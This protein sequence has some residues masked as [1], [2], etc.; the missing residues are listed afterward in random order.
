MALLSCGS[1]LDRLQLRVGWESSEAVVA[2]TAASRFGRMRL[3]RTLLS[4]HGIFAS[5]RVEHV[6]SL[7]PKSRR[8][9]PFTGCQTKHAC[10]ANGVRERYF[11][12][13]LASRVWLYVATV[14]AL[15]RQRHAGSISCPERPW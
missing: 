9:E 7:L 14:L 15:S 4:R 2:G 5:E 1:G 6:D 10:D 8:A 12:E 11:D 13:H 3:S